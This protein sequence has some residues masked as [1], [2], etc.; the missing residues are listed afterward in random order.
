MKTEEY[1]DYLQA[2]GIS[3]DDAGKQMGMVADFQQVSRTRRLERNHSRIREE[4][5]GE[6]C[7]EADRSTAQ[8]PG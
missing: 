3:T 1:R 5:S 8:H 2:K 4:G 7:P 6:I